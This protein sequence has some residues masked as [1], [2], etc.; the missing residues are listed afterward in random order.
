MSLLFLIL[1]FYLYTTSKLDYK[2]WDVNTVTAADFT[3]E[4]I[5]TEQAWNTFK[6][7]P[8][9]RSHPNIM[10]AFQSYLK[11][12]FE[13]IVQDVPGVLSQQ[14]VLIKISNIT[15]AFNNI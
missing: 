8:E 9:A 2:L 15:F 14:Q 1:I 6:S 13:H 10:N 12:E 7:M 11:R 3:A 5:I 4:Y